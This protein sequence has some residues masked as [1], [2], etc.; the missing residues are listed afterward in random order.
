MDRKGG[1]LGASTGA[2]A[3]MSCFVARRTARFC[4]SQGAAGRVFSVIAEKQELIARTAPSLPSDL[5]EQIKEAL[6]GLTPESLGVLPA[7]VANIRCRSGIAYQE[8]VSNANMTICIFLLKAG[9]HIP[10][11]DHPGMTVFGRLLFGRMRVLNFDPVPGP[12]GRLLPGGQRPIKA[13]LHSD[14]IVGPEPT[15]YGLGPE[16]GNL[17]EI[18]AIDDCAFFDIL[19]P[20]YNSSNRDITYFRCSVDDEAKKQYLLE[21]VDLWGFTMELQDYNGPAFRP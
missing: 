13:R 1:G 14:A 21:P 8:V 17:H 5:S 18:Q 3:A 20:P 9:S 4:S 7:E 15:S 11:H 10:L 6:E 19:T 12:E 2:V 16:D